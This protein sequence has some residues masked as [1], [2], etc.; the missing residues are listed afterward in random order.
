MRGRQIFY[1]LWHHALFTT[2]YS[3]FPIVRVHKF[4]DFRQQFDARL[5]G[6]IESDH[7]MAE[8]HIAKSLD[9]LG[10]FR[11]GTSDWI[12]PPVRGAG[13]GD[14]A[15]HRLDQRAGISPCFLHDPVHGPAPQ[16]GPAG[17]GPR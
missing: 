10:D 3:L 14:I 1:A 4:D 15:P 7:H 5:G 9:S 8:S 17:D 2:P 11:D 6:R 16:P 13:Q 12:G